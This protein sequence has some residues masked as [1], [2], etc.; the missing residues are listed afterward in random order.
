MRRRTGCLIVFLVLVLI[1]VIGFG[2]WP[3]L[4][5]SR[6]NCWCD[7]IDINS[8]RIRYRRYLA[9]LLVCTSIKETE[10]S[11]LVAAEG[12][13]EPPDWHTSNTLSPF[14][15]HSPHYLYHGATYQVHELEMMWNCATF[16]L[17]AKREIV[18]N[19]FLLWRRDGGHYSVDHY[20]NAFEPLLQRRWTMVRP[21]EWIESK[22]PI[23]TK[24]LPPLPPARK[25][26]GNSWGSYSEPS[27]LWS[28]PHCFRGCRSAGYLQFTLAGRPGRPT[29]CSGRF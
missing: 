20:L 24:D 6:L 8:G 13:A 17:A 16:T 22:E 7:D 23:D 1:W 9:G 15:N 29:K 27:M 18:R 10:L 19:V 28:S 25:Q 4:V 11:R 3:V 2:C 5:W 14:E 12:K 21:E 26:W